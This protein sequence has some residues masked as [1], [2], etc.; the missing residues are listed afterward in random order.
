MYNFMRF[1]KS[2]LDLMTPKREN[3]TKLYLHCESNC[4]TD[5]MPNSHFNLPRNVKL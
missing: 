4:R 2:I 1:S 5:F 3:K